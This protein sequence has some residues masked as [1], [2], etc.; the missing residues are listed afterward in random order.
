MALL[1]IPTCTFIPTC[2]TIPHFRVLMGFE[3]LNINQ[4]SYPPT[5]LFLSIEIEPGTLD[6]SFSLPQSYIKLK[7][8]DSLHNLARFI[9]KSRQNRFK[10]KVESQRFF[11]EPAKLIPMGL[12][13]SNLNQNSYAPR[14]AMLRIHSTFHNKEK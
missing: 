6:F 10:Q 13:Y 12:E 7:V 5:F 3:Y 4:N 1:N 11:S 9:C 2:A 14:F 8:Q